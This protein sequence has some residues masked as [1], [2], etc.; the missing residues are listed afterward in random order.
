MHAWLTA[1]AGSLAAAEA[2]PWWYNTLMFLKVL[3]G[4]S[5]IIF[6]HEL[7]HFLAA[8]WVGIRVDRFSVGFTYRLFGWRRGEGFTL[9]NRPNYKAEELDEKG[10]GETDY[11]FKLLPIGGYVKMLG[12]DDIVIDEKT[13]D[14]QMTDDPRAFTNRPVG[15]RMIVV[16][17][18]VVF[19]LLFAAVLLTCVFL[20]GKKMEAPVV[21]QVLPDGPASGKLLPGDRFI[22]VNGRTAD[23]FRDIQVATIFADGPLHFR[24]ERDEKLL[25][26]EVVVEPQM[27]DRLKIRTIG[28]TPQFTTTLSQDGRPVG[29]HP[30]VEKGDEVTHVDGKPVES[31]LDI[32]EVFANSRGRILEVMVKRWDSG[33]RDTPPQIVRCAQRAYLLVLPADL[34]AERSGSLTDNCHILGMQRRIAISAVERGEPADE[35]GFESGDVIAEWGTVANPLYEEIIDNITA[36]PG[37]S[38]RVLVERDGSPKELFVTPERKFKLLGKGK[39]KVGLE[40]NSQAEELRPVV[41]AVVP[42]TPA[43][44]LNM[45]RGSLIR[46]IDDQPVATWFDVIEILKVAAGRTVTVR[47]RT[48]AEEAVGSL[49]VPGSIVNELDLPPNTQILA[50]DGK[51]SISVAD[52]DG[53]TLELTLPNYWAVRKL[54]ERKV[55]QTVTVRFIRSFRAEPEEKS[56]TVPGDNLDP[57]Q[58]RLIYMCDQHFEVQTH[59]VRRSNPLSALGMGVK[60]AG[61]QVVE[62]YDFIRGLAKRN[63]GVRHVAGPVGIFR[64]AIE[65]AKQGWPELLF[66][67]GFLSVNLAVLNFLPVPV[68]D[69]GLM[70]FLIIE[71]LKGKPL[72][73]KAQMISTIVGLTT[74]VLCI[75][76]VT[77]QDISRYF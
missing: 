41:A 9:G 51:R 63:V 73:L 53:T 6:I 14:V 40:F 21:G 58:M 5:I 77:I 18:G 39:P 11:C 49:A 37:K 64:F 17:A 31:A 8:K 50:I 16:S 27:D 45:P 55:G 25:D 32:S 4:F 43:A 1:W 67:L 10:Y 28:V 46:A 48:G 13:G 12:Q 26:E 54:L 57:W 3:I 42:G 68:L 20:L 62:V 70:I 22:S 24:V 60:I 44:A 2:S 65:R 52:S 69:G 7:G 66:F 15:H 33:D 71:K 47:Y 56:F 30:N 59:I 61:Y 29:D 23:S 19:N 34:P 74:I 72:S 75:L 38:I 76:F 36:N 35:A